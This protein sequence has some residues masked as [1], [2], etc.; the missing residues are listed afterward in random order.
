MAAPNNVLSDGQ[1]GATA[2]TLL[3]GA[4]AP[5]SGLVDVLLNNTGTTEETV[6][7]T[8]QV[9]GGTARRVVR[10]VLNENQ[11]AHIRRVPVGF[12]DTLLAV[13]TTA[14]TV[15]YVVTIS[16]FSPSVDVLSGDGTNKAT[17]VLRRMLFGMELAHGDELPDPG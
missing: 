11:A 14:S 15:D 8:L 9:R 10:V 16:G 17:A 13:T 4:N 1:L 2:A 3:S 7:L 6:L 5:A 12:E